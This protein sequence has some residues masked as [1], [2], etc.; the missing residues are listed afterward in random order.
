MLGFLGVPLCLAIWYSLTN[1]SLNATQTHFVG[2]Q[3]FISL[4][5]N[6]VFLQALENT[7]IYGGAST[8]FTALIGTAMAFVLLPSYRGKAIIRFVMLLPWTIP[9][10]LSL[11]GWMWIFHPQFSVLNWV[12]EKMG[13]MSPPGI[14]WLGFPHTAMISIIMAN[15]WHNIPFAAIIFVAAIIGIPT[16]LIDAAK[17]D[18]AGWWKRLTRV[19]LPMAA[20]ILLL[21]LVFNMVFNFTDMTIVYLLT[22]GGPGNG[23]SI[24][25]FRAY[26][27]AILGGNLGRGAAVAI[28]MLPLI[29]LISILF[30]RAIKRS[31]AAVL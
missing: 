1:K 20:P 19:M 5:H 21:G 8:V 4:V 27:V 3:N 2:L 28:F 13:V 30:L 22:R 6:S 26:Q 23:T 12:G 17:V 18:G 25:T 24:L 11:V 15:V 9:I 31:T 14:Q 29:A 7:A 10:P 16:D